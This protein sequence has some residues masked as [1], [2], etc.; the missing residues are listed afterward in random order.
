MTDEYNAKRIQKAL[1]TQLSEMKL[2]IDY[3]KADR[4]KLN[5]KLDKAIEE[6]KS[7]LDIISLLIGIITRE[8]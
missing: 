6:R 2:E 3:L 7:L 8:Q 4:N 1:E 5:E